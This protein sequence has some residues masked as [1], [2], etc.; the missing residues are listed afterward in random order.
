MP[1]YPPHETGHCWWWYPQNPSQNR[2]SLKEWLRPSEA[3][4]NARLHEDHSIGLTGNPCP[5]ELGPV[6][7]SLPNSGIIFLGTPIVSYFSLYPVCPSKEHHLVHLLI[8]HVFASRLNRHFQCIVLQ[9]AGTGYVIWVV[10]G[11]PCI[12]GCYFKT[13]L[14][15]DILQVYLV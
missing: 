3:I 13:R 4:S 15:I 8:Q 14:Q 12:P 5:W 9:K 6:S 10:Q 2:H 1:L 11:N 7:V